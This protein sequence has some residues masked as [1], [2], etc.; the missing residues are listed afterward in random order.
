MTY[1]YFEIM[2]ELLFLRHFAPP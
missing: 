1:S 2:D